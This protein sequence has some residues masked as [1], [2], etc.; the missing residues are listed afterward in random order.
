ME[1]ILDKI[2]D[3]MPIIHSTIFIIG[4]SGNLALLIAAILSTPQTIKT[5]AIMIRC[6]TASDLVCICCDFFTIT[7]LLVVPG[8]ILYLFS[9]PCSHISTR[10]CYIAHSIRI[11]TLVYSGYVMLASFAF[12][13]HSVISGHPGLTPHVIFTIVYVVTTPG[14]VYGGLII[15]R[16]KLREFA[17]SMSLQSR[18]MHRNFVKALTI[19]ASLCPITIFGVLIYVALFFEVY[20]HPTMEKIVYTFAAFPPALTP[21]GFLYYVRPYR[22]FILSFFRRVPLVRSFAGSVVVVNVCQGDMTTVSS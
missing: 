16:H 6:G 1:V 13:I 12:R 5:Y 4:A 3:A 22:M 17:D 20:Y 19:H 10:S 8:N 14:P 11:V 7:R 9:G 21:Y 2:G 15:M 18:N